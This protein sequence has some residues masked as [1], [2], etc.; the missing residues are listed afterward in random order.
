[1]RGVKNKGVLPADWQIAKPWRWCDTKY[2]LNLNTDDSI[3]KVMIDAN[4]GVAD[5]DLSNNSFP[6]K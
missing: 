2:T 1:M 5:I 3:K 4:L 6:K